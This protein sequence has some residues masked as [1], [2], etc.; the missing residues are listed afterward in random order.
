M[1]GFGAMEFF[2]RQGETA[3][4]VAKTA[5]DRGTTILIVA[6]YALAVVAI[7]TKILPTF[8]GR[9]AANRVVVGP[10]PGTTMSGR[11]RSEGRATGTRKFAR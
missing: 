11:W 4:S 6:A 5:T 10:A 9:R 7:S 3:K 2:M 8:E 1:F